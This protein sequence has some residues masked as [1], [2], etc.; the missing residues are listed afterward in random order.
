[1]NEDHPA[2]PATPEFGEIADTTDT[3]PAAD[4]R[5]KNTDQ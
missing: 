2:Y 1:V 5:E 3:K 4:S